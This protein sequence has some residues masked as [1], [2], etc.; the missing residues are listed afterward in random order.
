MHCRLCLG[1]LAADIE[2]KEKELADLRDEYM[3]RACVKEG[4]DKD[5]ETKRRAKQAA[6]TKLPAASQSGDKQ[7]KAENVPV[8]DSWDEWE[9]TPP[10]IEERSK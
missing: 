7:S 9:S 4:L 2:L 6:S 1:R 3:R 10:S 5:D 8:S